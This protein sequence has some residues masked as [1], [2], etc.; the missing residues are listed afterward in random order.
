MTALD[1]YRQERTR[2][3]LVAIGIFKL[4]KS[5]SLFTLGTALVHWRGQDLGQVASQWINMFWLG[6]PFV[7]RIISKLSTF[8]EKSLEQVAAG[9]FIYSALLLIE[10]FGLCRRKRWAEFLTVG[11]TASLLPFEFYELVQ[12]FTATRVTITLVN[13]AILWFLIVQLMQDRNRKTMH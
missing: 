2:V 3:A 4:V 12:R 13:I 9:S 11:I 7:D 1:A 8:D 6:R 5:V 10:G